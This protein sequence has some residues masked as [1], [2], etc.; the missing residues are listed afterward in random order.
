VGEKVVTATEKRIPVSN[1]RNIKR[2]NGAS[3]RGITRN[4]KP[5]S[6]QRVEIRTVLKSPLHS[7][8]GLEKLFFFQI[9]NNEQEGGVYLP[10]R[11]FGEM[12]VGNEKRLNAPPTPEWR[13]KSL[14]KSV[15]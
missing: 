12:H 10:K 15:I 1:S 6:A 2:S 14:L 8:G 11:R 7:A 9:K 4:R 13:R 5:D 3:R